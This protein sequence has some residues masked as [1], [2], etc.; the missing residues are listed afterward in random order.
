VDQDGN[1]YVDDFVGWDSYEDDNDPFDEVQYGHGTGEAEDSTGE[2]DNGAGG[3]GVCP[4]C[5]VMHMRVGDSFIADVNDFAQGVLYATDNGASVVQSAL[6][7]LNNS[8]FAQEAIDYAYLRGVVLIAS[9]ADESAGHHNQPSV[10]EHAVT[11]NSI[12]EPEV[13]GAPPPSYLEFRG[14][15]NYGAYITA[16]VP[17]NS[18]SSEAVGRSAGMAGLLYAAG[19]TR[20][21]GARLPTTG[22]STVRAA[23]R[24]AARSRP[25]KSIRSSRRPP[26]T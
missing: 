17:S 22:S 10:L 16:A 12:G 1:G 11:M 6:G 8:R 2:V 14:C 25:R 3:A 19:R 15:T 5:V 20:W 7:T 18:C 26:T 23:F 13:G 4:N 21:P 24:G 9:A